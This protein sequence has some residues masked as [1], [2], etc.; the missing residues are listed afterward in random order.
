MYSLATAG[1][2]DSANTFKVCVL[3]LAEGS[4][5]SVYSLREAATDR[6]AFGKKSNESFRAGR[7]PRLLLLEW[8]PRIIP[9]LILL[10]NRRES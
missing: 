1:M 2:K 8:E 3:P 4:I 6:G 7:S 5:L 10:Q 9:F